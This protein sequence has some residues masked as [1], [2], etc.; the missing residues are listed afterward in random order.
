LRSRFTTRLVGLLTLA[1][2]AS[3]RP[4][5]ALLNIDGT[6]NQV[7]VFGNAAVSYDS[8]LFASAGGGGDYIY[9]ATVGVELKRRAGIIAVN[10]TATF[11]YQKYAE[12]TDQ[13][14]WNPSF[15]LEL[16]K[17]TGRTTGAFTINAVRSSRADSAVNLRTQTWNFPLGFNVKYPVNDKFYVT[18]GTGYLRRSYSDSG[19]GLLSYTDYSQAFDVFYVYT[20]KLDLL[21]GYR[22]R[23][24]NTSLGTTTDQ[25]FTIGLANGILPK[26]NGT[27]RVGYQ[28]RHSDN[29]GDTYHQFTTTAGL[30][31]TATRKFTA[32][33]SVSRDFQTTAVGGNV[34]SLSALLRGVYQYSRQFSID[35]SIGAGRNLFLSGT[36]RTDTFFSWDAGAKY[37]WNE[38]FEIGASYNYLK[39]WSTV[40]RSDFERSGYSV[41]V[42]SRY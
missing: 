31:W 36:P 22:L 14:G 1:L 30:T 28:I 20:S 40:S 15:F 41:N 37:R 9:G 42:S 6:R 17:T 5:N 18:S 33:L 19:A 25:A 29:T 26:V 38:H 34:D 16:N 39:N 2:L 8:N 11:D 27:L 35:G 10:A 13:S 12:F 7:F 24:G 32:N 23:V 21:G 4:A 3:P